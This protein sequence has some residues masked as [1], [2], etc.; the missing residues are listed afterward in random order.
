MIRK[1]LLPM[2]LIGL[3]AVVAAQQQPITV[4]APHTVEPEKIDTEMNARI[5]T[6]GTERSKVMWIEHYLTDVY[7]P[8]PTGSPNLEAAGKWAVTTMTSWGMKNAHLE[9]WEWGHPGWMPERAAGF[10]TSP[11]KANLKFEVVPWTP[12]TKGTVTGNVLALHLPQNPTEADLT[13]Y[14][15]SMASQVKGSIVMTA[16]WQEVP[17]DFNPPIKR[18][19]DDQV[20]AQYAPP[21]PNAPAGRG[22]RGG[23]GNRGG[24]APAADG[25]LTPQQVTQRVNQFLRDNPPALRLQDAARAHGIIVAQNQ[26]GQNYDEAG[27][28]PA[29]LLRNEDYGRIWRILQDGTPVTVEFNIV[30]HYYPGG[31]TA[32]NTIGEIPGTDKADEVVMLG[33]HLDSWASATGATDNAIGCAVM[34]E[35]VRILQAVGA[36]PRRTIRVALWSGEEEGLLGSLAYVKAHFGSAESPKQPEYSKFDG[37]WNIDGG[38]GRV[39]GAG[40]FGP[41]EAGVIIAQFLK[42]FE[43][44]G[45]F[46]ASTTTSRNTGGTD[47]TS[48]NNAGLPGI[49]GSQDAIEYNS[50]TH[51]TDLDTY[52]RIVPEDVMKNAM[53]TASVV[54]H[55]AN[56]E[57]MLPR[58]SADQMPAPPAPRGGGLR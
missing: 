54:Y 27:Q 8:R 18:R 48:F 14:L 23:R 51:H 2:L 52:E 46:G 35:A 38:T 34:L 20:R 19:P 41:P 4:W 36:K 56:R 37:Y 58:F 33:G 32:Y 55:I 29:V 16:A 50:H 42:P 30:N 49:G 44:L 39:R 1:M 15:A 26:P 11:V 43:D 7:G 10:I 12:S 31:K 57:K 24:A 13:T 22:G 28:I 9:P 21:G 53:I 3:V 40:I 45:V 25:R 6:E 47:S 5:R 17:V